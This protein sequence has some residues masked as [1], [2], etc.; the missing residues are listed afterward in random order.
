M[1][2][3]VQHHPKHNRRQRNIRQNR[4]RRTMR[5]QPRRSTLHVNPTSKAHASSNPSP[6]VKPIISRLA[7]NAKSDFIS[8]MP[9]HPGPNG[10]AIIAAL[11]T[12]RIAFVAAVPDIVTSDALL[13][14]I[15]RDPTIRLIR[16]CKEDEGVAI[17]TGLAFTGHRAILMMQQTGLLDSINAIRAIAVEYAQPVC[18]LVGLQGKEP[19]LPP[20]QSAK[21]AVR[22]VEPILDA[23][24]LDHIALEDPEDVPNLAPAIERAYAQSRPLVA[25]IGRTVA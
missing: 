10:A 21:F 8:G 20:A 9:N 13:W 25:L 17:C 16:L 4:P 2:H 11:K 7:P 1:H 15:S 22:I 12:A 5:R 6:T 18:M 23:M 19:H 3:S 24:G 14:L